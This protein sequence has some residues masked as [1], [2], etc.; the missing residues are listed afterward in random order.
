M[1]RINRLILKFEGLFGFLLPASTPRI[2][3][4]GGGTPAQTIAV[5]EKLVIGGNDQWV[6]ERSENTD[7]P[8][9]LFLHGGPGTSQLTMNRKNTKELEKSFIVVNWDQRGAGKSYKAITD[10]CKMNIDQ[11]VADTRELTLYL[12]KKFRKKRIILLGHSWGSVIG[13]ITAS[14]YPE[15]Y[16][17]Y[18]GVGQIANMEEGERES[19]HW[20]IRQAVERKDARAIAALQNI[21]PPPYQ[22]DWQ[23]KIINERRLLAR[24]GGEVYASKSGAFSMVLRSLLFSREYSFMD[25][26]NFFRGVLGSQRLLWPELLK[27]DLFKSIREFVIPVYLLEGRQD[28]EVP[29]TVAERYFDEIKAPSKELIWFEN[30]AH[31]V[32]FEERD[33]FNKVLV[34]RIRPSIV[35]EESAKSV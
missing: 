1:N 9:I 21:G 32:S 15:L 3:S 13:A 34:D 25:R 12:L 18:V 22:G 23:A 17:C 29:S 14:R 27:V 30:S 26:I 5:L 2:I 19:Y 31:M 7:N 28:H 10:A 16:Y 8:I 20:T 35:L 24:F 4:N 6:L 11:F 33:K